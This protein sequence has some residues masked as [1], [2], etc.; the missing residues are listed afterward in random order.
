[1]TSGSKA[2]SAGASFSRCLSL[3]NN[4][5]PLTRTGLR[6]SIPYQRLHLGTTW[7]QATITFTP[8]DG[9]L[10]RVDA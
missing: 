2:A 9:V 8:Y 7:V 1:M 5:E 3:Q 4:F 10:D 6:G